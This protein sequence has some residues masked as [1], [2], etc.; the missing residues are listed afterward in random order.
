MSTKGPG[1]NDNLAERKIKGTVALPR[2]VSKGVW[3]RESPPFSKS[4]AV[5][6]SLW[7]RVQR[8]QVCAQRKKYPVLEYPIRIQSQARQHQC[9]RMFMSPSTPK[10]F[11]AFLGGS[12]RMREDGE[13]KVLDLLPH[14]VTGFHGHW[15]E[16][17]HWILRIAEDWACHVKHPTILILV[18]SKVLFISWKRQEIEEPAW[19]II[20]VWA[21]EFD[22]VSWPDRPERGEKNKNEKQ[23][24]N[25]SCS[26][27]PPYQVPLGHYQL[28][29]SMALSSPERRNTWGSMDSYWPRYRLTM[30]C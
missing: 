10:A 20:F 1:R 11:A 14:P 24:Q 29:L 28:F 18:A 17:C 15:G 6:K 19:D 26:K 12:E 27:L 22:K 2:T 21:K 16:A 5:Q 9:R 7:V 4:S 30:V 13:R 25:K 8:L 3:H 23:K